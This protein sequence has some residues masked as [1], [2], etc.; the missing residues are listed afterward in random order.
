MKN[1][2]ERGIISFN[3]IVELYDC[4]YLVKPIRPVGKWLSTRD[5]CFDSAAFEASEPLEA[6]IPTKAICFSDLHI[7]LPSSRIAILNAGRCRARI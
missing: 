2:I 5:G 6:A 7:G 3:H 1:A 4:F